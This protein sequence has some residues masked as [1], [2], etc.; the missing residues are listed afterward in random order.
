MT[1]LEELD[2]GSARETSVRSFRTIKDLKT[3][4]EDE[5]KDMKHLFKKVDLDS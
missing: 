3:N 5:M 4:R 1:T 2:K